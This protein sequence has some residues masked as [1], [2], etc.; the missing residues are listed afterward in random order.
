LRAATRAK[1]CRKKVAFCDKLLRACARNAL[2]NLSK[3]GLPIRTLALA[4][5]TIQMASKRFNISIAEEMADINYLGDWVAAERCRHFR[6]RLTAIAFLSSGKRSG[7]KKTPQ[8]DLKSG[9]TR[10]RRT[11]FARV[12]REISSRRDRIAALMIRFG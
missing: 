10:R 2:L 12:G 6:S 11:C 9:T 3:S 7:S 4:P 5:A 8:S 1:C